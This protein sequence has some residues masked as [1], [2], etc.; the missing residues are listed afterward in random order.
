MSN[1]AALYIRVSSDEQAKHGLSLGEQRAEL[2]EYAKERGYAIVDIY[3]DEGLTARKA[4]SRRKQ[5][6]RLLCDVRAGHIDIIV[7]K[8]LDRWF[9]NVKDYYHVQEILDKYGVLWEC[10][11]EKYNTT[12]A[13]GRFWLHMKLSIAQHESDQTG[14]RI[15]YVFDGKRKRHEV[16]TGNMP[17]GYQVVNK[18][19][20][21]D[22]NAPIVR[23]MYD[24]VANGGSARTV[25]KAVLDRY[26]VTL[27]YRQAR[28]IL[29][30]K[31]YI[32]EFYNVPDY[33]PPVVKYEVFQKV[34]GILSQ[35]NKKIA[36]TGRVYLFSSLIR[37][38]SCGR[39]LSGNR[40]NPD[41]HGVFNCFQYRCN[42]QSINF[43]VDRCTFKR[44]LFEHKLEHYLL[45]NIQ[46]LLA[47]HIYNISSS[48]EKQDEKGI[49]AEL[50]AVK[51]RILRLKDI[52][53]D[54]MIDKDIYEKDYMALRRKADE[55]SVLIDKAPAFHPEAWDTVTSG[56]FK[57]TYEALSRENKRRF[58]QSII[59]SITFEDTPES[60]GKGGKFVFH[61][62][63]L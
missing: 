40:G 57:D 30:N 7:M 23:Y 43:G 45:E 27:T 32:G 33:C 29:S 48:K 52:Y 20:E 12:T 31:C 55:L 16:L 53:L 47:D 6:Q 18:H 19:P 25:M 56:D 58:W 44:A 38:P 49:A 9:R 22:E 50:E 21:M 13:N 15:R 2:I 1:R 39:T 26:G 51:A 11:Q 35:R 59:S 46:K 24:Y 41:R 14:E 37:C 5:L 4:I 3:A 54:G 8:C 42:S 62:D 17:F 10:S 34:Q 63:F 36:P 61:V 28:H 60:R